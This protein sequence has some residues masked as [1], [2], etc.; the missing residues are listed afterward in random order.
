[1]A[2]TP[3]PLPVTHAI[4][5][6]APP[7]SLV[8][9]GRRS[10]FAN[11]DVLT[12]YLEQSLKVPNLILPERISTCNGRQCGDTFPG[13]NGPDKPS[14]WTENWTAQYRV[15]GDSPSQRAAEDITFAIAHFFFAR[16][17]TL[18]NYYMYHGGTDFGRTSSSFVTTRYYD[19]APLDEF[20]LKREPKFEHL[21]DLHRALRLSKKPLLWGTQS[22]QKIN[23]D[24]E[25]TTY[26][27]AGKDICVAFLTNNNTREDATINFRGVDYSY[28]LN[29]LAFSL[30]V[31]SQHSSRNFVPSKKSKITKWEMYKEMVPGLHDL[32][33]KTKSPKELYMFTKDIPPTMLGI[34]QGTINLEKREL[35]MRPDIRPVL[36]IASLGHALAAFVNGEYVLGMEVMSKRAL[37][38]IT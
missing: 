37:F 24:L 6:R 2:M 16:N 32:E 26:E 11:D 33:I 8:A 15:F 19:E 3:E 1:M 9:P 34:T 38:S 10:L 28:Q 7:P 12:E 20:G 18:N 25:I 17:G 13:P 35:P 27:K 5:F 4:S 23:E 31:V 36:Q 21:R 29:P 14:L 30:I 22:V